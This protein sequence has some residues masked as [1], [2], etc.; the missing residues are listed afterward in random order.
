MHIIYD[1]DNEV[2]L[3]KIYDVLA[4]LFDAA[5]R[6]NGDGDIIFKKSGMSSLCDEYVNELMPFSYN[7]QWENPNVQYNPK[8][9]FFE[10][11]PEMDD[12]HKFLFLKSISENANFYN[13]KVG[14]VKSCLEALGFSLESS[15]DTKSGYT[16]TQTTKGLI[17]RGEDITRLEKRLRDDFPIVYKYYDEALSTFV[18]GEY[19]SCIDNCRTMF[20]KLTDEFDGET[21][22]KKILGITAERVI[23]GTALLTSRKQI[24]NYW[25]NNKK[26]ANRFRYFTTLYSVMSGLGTHGEEAPTKADAVLILRAIE[27]VF[28]W[29]LKI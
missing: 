23:D 17:E 22:D 20:D 8:R 26:G 1:D 7:G 19:K 16:I 6:K 9:V 11:Y 5:L 18:N 3:C 27:D 2:A 25:I 29:I 12:K 13:L 10:I 21:P 28:V 15:A 24:F 4:D 14:Y